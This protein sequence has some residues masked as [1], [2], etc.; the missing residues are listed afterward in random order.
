M[1]I[2]SSTYVIT[3][4]LICHDIQAHMWLHLFYIWCRCMCRRS[5]WSARRYWRGRVRWFVALW[6][7]VSAGDSCLS[8]WRI[9]A[10]QHVCLSNTYTYART[11]ARMFTDSRFVCAYM[12]SPGSRQFRTSKQT[13]CVHKCLLL[14]WMCV[15]LRHR[16][17][18]EWSDCFVHPDELHA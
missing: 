16:M 1:W 7:L 8:V 18:R 6:K 5:W 11:Y 10:W 17:H 15:I 14:I 3:L 13:T 4:K 2:L 12:Y 9:F